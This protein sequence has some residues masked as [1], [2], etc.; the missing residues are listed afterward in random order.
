M[1]IRNYVNWCFDGMWISYCWSG[2]VGWVAP[3]EAEGYRGRAQH[4]VPPGWLEESDLAGVIL[5]R[6]PVTVALE[7]P[8]FVKANLHNHPS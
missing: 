3:N 7:F 2:L 8:T 4:G 6:C 5:Q 1:I